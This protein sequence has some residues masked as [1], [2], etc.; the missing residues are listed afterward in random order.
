MPPSSCDGDSMDRQVSAASRYGLQ[1]FWL[2]MSLLR[3]VPPNLFNCTAMFL[4]SVL[5]N[6]STSG[7]LRGEKM[8]PCLLQG[9]GQLE[10]AALP[11]DD[12]YG[13]HFNSENFHFAACACLVRG[14]TDTVTKATALRVLST[15]LEMSTG[16]NG[17]S[18]ATPPGAGGGSLNGGGADSS[19]SIRELSSSPYMALILARTVS[20]D[21]L[22][23]S[24][25]SVG[26]NPSGLLSPTSATAPVA[27]AVAAAG[28]VA[29][30]V[31]G[32][33]PVAASG[34]ASKSAK[35]GIRGGN[36]PDG[37]SGLRRGG[38]D[39][40][41]MKDKDLLLNTAIELIDFQYLDDAVQNRTL[42][43]LNEIAV[44]RPTVVMHLCGP[45]IQILDDI[46]LH[47]QNSA[48][49]ESAHRLLQTLTGNSKF[50]SYHSESNEMLNELLE[51]EGFGGLWRSCTFNMSQEQ[52]KQCFVLTE[53]LIEVCLSPREFGEI[54]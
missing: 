39:L 12:A 43:W 49:L 32:G 44:A 45:I 53:K 47:C 33:I 3:L 4:E 27:V 9:R 5:T 52:D 29:G 19:K 41:V 15:F 7:D 48:T 16:V 6:I 42:Q 22:R 38:Q 50:S 51:D 8:V 34:G 31:A 35:G 24:L 1:L 25:W 37:V 2:A 28:A 30:A 20:V 11:L 36:I 46:V 40:A 23:D 10:D 13:I 14:L 26:I 18:A 17:S 21:E 54:W